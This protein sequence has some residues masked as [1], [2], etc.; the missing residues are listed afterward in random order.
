[1]FVLGQK[2]KGERRPQRPGDGRDVRE[3]A[4]PT[5]KAKNKKQKHTHKTGVNLY[6]PGLT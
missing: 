2:D 4:T 3:S 5:K 6:G 1:M